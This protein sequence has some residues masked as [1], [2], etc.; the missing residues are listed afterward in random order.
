[1]S[2]DLQN[3]KC[4]SSLVVFRKMYDSRQSIYD[5]ISEFAKTVIISH[6]LTTFELHDMCNFM[7]KE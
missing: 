3:F 7:K 5:I 2:Q 4:V 1:M 6:S